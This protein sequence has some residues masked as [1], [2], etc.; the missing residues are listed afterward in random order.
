MLSEFVARRLGHLALY[1]ALAA[2]LLSRTAGGV[3]D[4]DLYHEM[5]LAREAI[6]LGYVPW[7]DS[8]A[9]TPTVDVVVHHEWG[10]GLIALGLSQLGGGTAI[11]ALKFLLI[12]GLGF[13]VWSIAR[14]R[15]G[16]PVVI[17]F[18]C[19][20]GIVLSDFG[21]ATVRAQMFSYLFAALLLWG[22]DRDRKGERS[23]LLGVAV[24]F[25]VWANLH[26]GCL[27]G[28][29]LFATHWIEQLVRRQ[30]H[31]H[32]FWV[33]LCLIPLAAINPWGFHFH[34][35]LLRAITMPRPAIA[36]WSPLWAEENRMQL[37]NFGLS[38]LPLLLVL[39]HQGWR[40][41]P[42]ILLVFVTALAALKS[43]RFLPF[44]AIAFAAYLPGA[45]S[46]IPLGRDL[47]RWWHT[48]QPAIAAVLGLA[49]VG[50]VLGALP[51]EPWRL[52]VASHPLPHQGAHLIYP[53][54]AVNYLADH[55]FHG[56]VMVPYDWG[57][58]VMWK[59][60]PDVKISFDSRY[61]VAYPTWRM[62]ED[63]ILYEAR[64]GWDQVLSKYPADALLVRAD[65]PIAKSLQQKPGWERVYA[66]P[67][68]VLFAQSNL[69]LPIVESRRPAPEGLFP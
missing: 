54:G 18:F 64:D 32:L 62:D 27:V 4:L 51:S 65:L 42:G 35:Y 39:K 41:I 23:W 60:G 44:Y 2:F 30:P 38:L 56:N 28:A 8:F 55:Q 11:I 50:L 53:V 52:Q 58:Y 12:F 19:A 34:Q 7:R 49:A 46:L 25:P 16:R 63:D 37:M 22:F 31:W 67:Q 33:G 43:N 15:H 59:L 68:F 6:R 57:S 69:N 13:V 1:G 40:R 48:Y 66:D 3:I 20:L 24:L 47:R 61:E 5:S 9:F 29:A 17:S 10:L 45:F 21:F 14:Q 36:E 26:G